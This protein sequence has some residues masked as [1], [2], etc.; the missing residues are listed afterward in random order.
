MEPAVA[1]PNVGTD[2]APAA[3]AAEP[4]THERPAVDAPTKAAPAGQRV[5]DTTPD[6]TPKAPTNKW[7]AMRDVLGD[8]SSVLEQVTE[9]RVSRETATET[10][11][12]TKSAAATATADATKT[13]AETKPETDGA[14]ARH[15]TIVGPDGKPT[16]FKWPE[17]AKVQLTIG[18]K[19]VSF[20]SLDDM[21]KHAQLGPM[22]GQLDARLQH[23]RRAWGDE[24]KTLEASFKEN[25][26]EIG[27]RN[28]KLFL[29]ALFQDQYDPET[30]EGRLVAQWRERYGHLANPDAVRASMAESRLT[31][32][33]EREQSDAAEAAEREAAERGNRF[34][35]GT[36]A[37]AKSKLSEYPFLD[38]SD[39]PEIIDQFYGDYERHREQLQAQY[40]ETIPRSNPD[41]SE[42][43]ILEAAETDAQE[44]LSSV[45]LLKIFARRNDAYKARAEK[46]GGKSASAN[47][48]P[49]GSTVDGAQQEADAHNDRIHTKMTQR[50]R[51]QSLLHG[52]PTGAGA[53]RPGTS[54]PRPTRWDGEGGHR[55]SISDEFA[56]LKERSA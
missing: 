21:V 23:E 55:A 11:P 35:E 22:V 45:N 2:V 42:D 53:R 41:A 34:W 50:E 18:G 56:K 40:L 36:K 49:G 15:Y 32:R 51:T 31:E 38:E 14:K 33:D 29:T 27:E 10:K 46:H 54:I 25:V 9:E 3:P 48:A 17:G 4:T 13:S 7:T 8:A 1:E 44:Y 30:K 12:E 28:V 16:E 39:V 37:F 47:G 20:G 5:S 24:K 19:Q 26:R 52:K 6:T 43:E